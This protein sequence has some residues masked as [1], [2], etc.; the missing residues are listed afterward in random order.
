M[1]NPRCG[2]AVRS[3]QAILLR[4]IRGRAV[5]LMGQQVRIGV[6]DPHPVGIAPCMKPTRSRTYEQRIIRRQIN[7]MVEIECET[8]ACCYVIAGIGPSRVGT[9]VYEQIAYTQWN[10]TSGTDRVCM[11]S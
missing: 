6:I 4:R 5:V 8:Q 2:F 3:Q 11:P 1:K 10:D 9:L 7:Y